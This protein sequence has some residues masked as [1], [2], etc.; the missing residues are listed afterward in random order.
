VK[1]DAAG[2]I[3]GGLWKTL[4]AIIAQQTLFPTLWLHMG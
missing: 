3:N 2:P 4:A 1:G